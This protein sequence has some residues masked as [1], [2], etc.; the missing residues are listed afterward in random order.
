MLLPG[1]NADLQ[2]S[3]RIRQ[4]MLQ[5]L[6]RIVGI[7]PRPHLSRFGKGQYF[8]W[9]IGSSGRSPFSVV[10]STLTDKKTTHCL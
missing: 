3:T 6:S 8:S 9:Q 10:G 5:A 7:R 1:R 2:P 4:S